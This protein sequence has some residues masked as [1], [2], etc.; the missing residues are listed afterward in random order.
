MNGTFFI[1]AALVL[2]AAGE[3]HLRKKRRDYHRSLIGEFEEKENKRD[4]YDGMNKAV[5]D[6]KAGRLYN[7]GV[8]K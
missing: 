1:I 6:K 7:F 2:L 8:I 4:T 5:I 3:R